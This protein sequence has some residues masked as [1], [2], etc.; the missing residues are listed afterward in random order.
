MGTRGDLTI[1]GFDIWRERETICVMTTRECDDGSSGLLAGLVG[2]LAFVL[3]VSLLVHH[4]FGMIGIIIAAIIIIPLA[5]LAYNIL[6]AILGGLR[7]VY[8]AIR[9]WNG[10]PATP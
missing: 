1:L 2:L 4:P 3:F 8:R 10:P 6:A 9:Y 5:M 7:G